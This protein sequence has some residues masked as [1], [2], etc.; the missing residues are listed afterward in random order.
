MLHDLSIL[1]C[2]ERQVQL[3]HAGGSIMTGAHEIPKCR[4]TRTTRDHAAMCLYP[5]HEAHNCSPGW[6]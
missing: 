3:I 5:Q 6:G 4:F 2:F 1:F